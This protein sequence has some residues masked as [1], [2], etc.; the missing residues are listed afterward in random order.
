MTQSRGLAG[1]PSI[2][3]LSASKR[4]S[5]RSPFIQ[6]GL[7][8]MARLRSSSLRLKRR[9]PQLGDGDEEVAAHAAHLV[10]DAAF[11]LPERGLQNL[12]RKP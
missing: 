5:S 8:D 3:S 2:A 11:S 12:K 7:S 1:S 6:W 4:S 9:R 10:L